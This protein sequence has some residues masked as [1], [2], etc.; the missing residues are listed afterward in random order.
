MTVFDVYDVFM[1]V[2]LP[3]DFDL[4]KTY[5]HSAKKSV[6]K[7]KG[8]YRKTDTTFSYVES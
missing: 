7:E 4:S 8:I 3:Q 6:D 2:T 5:D 1:E